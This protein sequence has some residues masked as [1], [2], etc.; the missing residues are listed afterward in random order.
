MYN[1]NHI[2]NMYDSLGGGKC[3]EQYKTCTAVWV[4]SFKCDFLVYE[5]SLENRKQLFIHKT[6]IAY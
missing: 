5:F 4:E 3:I 1:K 2:L 6:N